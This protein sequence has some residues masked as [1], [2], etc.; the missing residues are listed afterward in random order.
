[1]YWSRSLAHTVRLYNVAEFCLWLTH[2]SHKKSDRF[3][4]DTQYR[5]GVMV[6]LPYFQL[7]YHQTN[8][9]AVISVLHIGACCYLQALLSSQTTSCIVPDNKIILVIII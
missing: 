4:I 9:K 1:M 8:F 7:V 6:D 2:T 5:N 3:D